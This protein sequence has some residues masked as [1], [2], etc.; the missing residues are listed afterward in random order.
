[1]HARMRD[2]IREDLRTIVGDAAFSVDALRNSCILVTGG[3]GFVGT[4]VAELCTFLNDEHGFNT[5]ILLLSRNPHTLEG[6]APH[7]VQ[8]KDVALIAKDVR[9]IIDIPGDVEWIIHAAGTPDNSIH[10]SDPLRVMQVIGQG[11][12]AVLDSA[13]RLTQLKRIMNVSSGLVYGQQPLDVERLSET[14]FYGFNCASVGSIYA[15]AKRFAE[16]LCSAFR[17]IQRLPIIITRPFAFI[18]PYQRLDRPWAINNFMRDT[19]MGGPIRILGDGQ[20]VRSYMYAAEMAWW[21]LCLL[22]KGASGASYNVGSPHGISLLDLAGKILQSCGGTQAILT[23][24][25]QGFSAK[26]S[27]F[28]PDV[29]LAERSLGLKVRMDLDGAIRRTILWH[30]TM[31][32]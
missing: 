12:G 24:Q 26:R 15:E 29:G 18:G 19:L 14:S 3:T 13:S 7:L 31:A 11:L 16:S 10:A 32:V 5:R 6:A 1:M 22:V 8:R 21:M 4:W 20:T 25:T 9:S 30:R 28:V 17:N 2:F 23:S 27:R